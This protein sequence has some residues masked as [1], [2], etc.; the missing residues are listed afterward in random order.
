VSGPPMYFLNAC[1]TFV[2]KTA[3]E[4]QKTTVAYGIGDEDEK[5]N[6][7]NLTTDGK[8]ERKKAR[9]EVMV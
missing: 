5:T 1:Q 7:Q 8:E 2:G 6:T 9:V 3:M 4:K